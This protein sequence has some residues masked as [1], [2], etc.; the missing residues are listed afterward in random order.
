MEMH[1]KC[2]AADRC[3]GLGRT[4]CRRSN[5]LRVNYCN[6][7]AAQQKHYCAVCC[8]CCFVSLGCGKWLSAA[9]L[10]VC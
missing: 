1:F 6:C 3:L 7:A 4:L 8:C 9:S 10:A 2:A 5:F